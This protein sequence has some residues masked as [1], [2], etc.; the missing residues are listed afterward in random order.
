MVEG[1]INKN[2][3]FAASLVA[4]E[5]EKEAM[6]TPSGDYDENQNIYSSLGAWR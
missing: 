4:R 1:S 2:Q 6:A 5:I 3:Y